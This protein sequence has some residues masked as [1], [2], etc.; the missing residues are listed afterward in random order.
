MPR[1]SVIIP[2][3]NRARLV[4]QTIDSVLAQ[5]YP[6]FEVIVVDDGST[7][8]TRAVLAHYGA[9]IKYIYQENQGQPAARNKGLL[10]SQ[11][12]YLLLLDSDDLVLLNKLELQAS[13]LEAWPDFGLVYSGWQFI[14]QV[15]E[16]LGEVRPNKQGQLLKDLLLRKFNFP[17]HAA[18]VRR[19]CFDRAGLFDES[20][21][22]GDDADMWRRIAKAGYAFGC[23]EQPLIQYR[24]HQDG[25]YSSVSPQ[26]IQCRF[27]SLDKF[28]ADPDLPDDIKALRAETYGV[29]HYETARRYYRAG[30]IDLGQEH[31]RKAI[32]THPPLSSNKEWLLDWIT[33]PVADPR[34]TDPLQAINLILANLP[35]EATT[36][37]SLRRR[38]RGR[39]HT[40]TI[41][42]EYQKRRLKTI[43]RHIL[44]AVLG[45]PS[46]LRNRGFISISCQALM[47]LLH[48]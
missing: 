44:P 39:Y 47:A 30:K 45:D 36:L 15:G 19:D 3:Y 22:R 5:T 32:A 24:I 38:I 20:L 37:H 28:F 21:L 43:P 31:L 35:A 42:Y 18:L 26:D 23:I 25:L 2:T 1:V 46:I 16:I 27:A 41:F 8:N 14:N 48:E 13:F 7:D 9:R 17:I 10:A 33:S 4:T 12:E 34:V 6:D 40:K 29:L 11:G